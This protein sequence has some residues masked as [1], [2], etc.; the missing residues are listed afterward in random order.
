MISTLK[1]DIYRSNDNVSPKWACLVL[2]L[3]LAR[4]EN[5]SGT[6][7]ENVGNFCFSFERAVL[8]S[9]DPPT[10]DGK[11]SLRLRCNIK[12]D[13]CRPSRSYAGKDPAAWSQQ[14][15]R[16]LGLN[17]GVVSGMSDAL[18]TSDTRNS[19]HHLS[20]L[21]RNGPHK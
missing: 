19:P 18:R 11:I 14:C 9:A 1:E 10:P 17:I 2:V 7:Y 12:D 8:Y 5:V 15:L 4:Y 3:H 6:R 20:P 13:D 16:G 21:F